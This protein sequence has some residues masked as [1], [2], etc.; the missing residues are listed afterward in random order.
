[1]DFCLG[2]EDDF[3]FDVTKIWKPGENFL[4]NTFHF[5]SFE[6]LPDEN[7]VEDGYWGEDPES[8]VF[9]PAS[10]WFFM[11]DIINDELS[12]IPFY[13]NRISVQDRA[14]RKGIN[15]S[16]YPEDGYFDFKTLKKGHTIL[17]TN[18]QKHD[19]LDFS[20]G[21]RIEQLDSVSVAPCNMSDLL[22]LSNLYYGKKDRK[23]WW[24]DKEDTTPQ[25]VSAAAE[26]SVAA[27]HG[28][29]K[30]CMACK[31]ARYCSKDCQA[32]HWKE[33]HKRTCKVVPIFRKLTDI[34]Y[35]K[36]DEKAFLRR[37]HFLDSLALFSHMMN[38]QSSYMNN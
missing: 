34:N 30:K 28:E 3:A 12:Q 20:T 4:Q 25:P 7:D 5:P 29:L 32:K 9:T 14:G 36:Y 1:M 26:A 35:A 24:C 8:G 2:D 31:M 16:F 11:A 37:G 15:I 6:S 21:L 23:C 38:Q 17:V 19:F 18:G 27:G 33:W 13:R 10:T 22:L